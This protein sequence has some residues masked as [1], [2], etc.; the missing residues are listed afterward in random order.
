MTRIPATLAILALLSPTATAEPCA[1]RVE[2][3]GDRDAMARVAVELKTLGVVLGP[4]EPA[5]DS[6]PE[7]GARGSVTRARSCSFN[8]MVTLEG[9]G[10]SI[11]VKNSSA[12]SEGRVVSDAKVAAV[13]IDSWLRDEI[14]VSSWAIAAPPSAPLSTLNAMPAP[15]P[16]L[17]GTTSVTA[18]AAA[19]ESSIFER[20]GLSFAVERTWTNDETKWNG[21]DIAG[22]MRLGMTCIG[23]RVRAGFQ[24]DLAYLASTAD[25]SD[26]VALATLSIPLPVGQIW[27]APEIGIGVG[28]IHTKRVDAC[29]APTPPPM[30]E[31]G[32][33]DPMDPTCMSEPNTGAGNECLDAAGLPTNELYVGDDYDKSTYLPRVALALRL[34]FPIVRHVWLDAVASYTATP[35]TPSTPFVDPETMVSSPTTAM[36]P[37]PTRGYQLGIGIRVG[38]P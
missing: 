28:R 11:A 10:L 9:D 3:S 30:T 6:G 21:F 38:I 15:A 4:I 34:S 16:M 19:S 12:R 7:P 27:V 29:Y 13:W 37:E 35:I 26:L 14:E 8:A 25:R 31:P 33:S 36:P 17:G 1:P 24:E 18:P 22:C 32:C 23:G 5:S 2:L 20:V